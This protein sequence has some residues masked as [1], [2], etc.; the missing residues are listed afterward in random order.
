MA[1]TQ[2]TGKISRIRTLCPLCPNHD[3][4]VA[5]VQNGRITSLEGDREHPITRGHICN[6]GRHAWETIYHPHRF[7]RPLLRAAWAGMLL[8]A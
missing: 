6:K 4:I 1:A 7:K 3:G 5:T 2:G 8:Q